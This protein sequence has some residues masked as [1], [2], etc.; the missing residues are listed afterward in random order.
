MEQDTF[1]Q[2]HDELMK[3]FFKLFLSNQEFSSKWDMEFKLALEMEGRKID[4]EYISQVT[5]DAFT[6]LLKL[7]NSCIEE[8]ERNKSI[9]KPKNDGMNLFFR[10]FLTD[11]LDNLAKSFRENSSFLQPNQLLIITGLTLYQEYKNYLFAKKQIFKILVF[12][13]NFSLDVGDKREIALFKNIKI[14]KDLNSDYFFN[15]DEFLGFRKDTALV[16]EFETE[17][18]GN[19]GNTG[20][21]GN[22]VFVVNNFQYPN[23]R[24]KEMKKELDAILTAF[25]LLKRGDI[26][27]LAVKYVNPSPFSTPFNLPPDLDFLVQFQG[28]DYKFDKSDLKKFKSFYKKIKEK[29]V[30]NELDICISRFNKSYTRNDITDQI[31][32]LVI[33]MEAI[34]TETKDSIAYKIKTQLARLIERNKIK[35]KDLACKIN[36][37]YGIRSS[38]VHGRNSEEIGNSKKFANNRELL[39][40]TREI[41]RKTIVKI[42]NLIKTGKKLS[43]IF[44]NVI[45]S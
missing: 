1:D 13:S 9:L 31:I 6:D 38:L 10:I 17:K 28:E 37:I 36:S 32:D 23:E 20:N 44:D 26:G 16:F 39:E 11:L 12:L 33:A 3:S 22:G 27:I 19:F 34:T 18:F 42:L 35:R 43:E 29:S 2:K 4:K 7:F 24:T 21:G 25:R 40:E 45:Y 41:S 8:I 30:C 14:I 15:R 5:Q